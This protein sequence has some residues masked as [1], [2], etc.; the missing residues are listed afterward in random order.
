[1]TKSNISKMLEHY[2]NS[3]IQE[4]TKIREILQQTALLGLERHGLSIFQS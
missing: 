3:K 1:M 4:Q 2:Q